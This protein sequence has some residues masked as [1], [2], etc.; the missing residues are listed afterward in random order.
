MRFCITK[1]K[2]MNAP[3]GVT[4]VNAALGALSDTTRMAAEISLV[5]DETLPPAKLAAGVGKKK[6]R[7]RE[8]RAAGMELLCRAAAV[9]AAGDWARLG[10]VGVNGVSGTVTTAMANVVTPKKE[11]KKR[12]ARKRTKA[13]KKKGVAG[14][15]GSTSAV[16][17]GNGM[18]SVGVLGVSESS[19]GR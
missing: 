5:A 12:V 4:G 18:A 13:A 11:G 3:V 15:V 10:V 17:S 19:W 9:V 6:R 2:G 16:A 14:V 1:Q 7:R 8:P